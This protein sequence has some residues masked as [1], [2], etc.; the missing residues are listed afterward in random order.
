MVELFR[1]ERRRLL[2][3]WS[4]RYSSRSMAA[5]TRD[6]TSAD[7]AGSVLITR[8][9]VF[10]LTPASAA[11]S[12]MVGRPRAPVPAFGNVNLLCPGTSRRARLAN[13]AC[14]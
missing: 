6:R 4:C 7:T 3:A 12:R 9:T 8:E 1:S 10:K 14:A 13:W 5:R 2:A 11:T